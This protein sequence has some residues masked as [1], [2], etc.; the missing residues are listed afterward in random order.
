MLQKTLKPTPNNKLQKKFIKLFHSLGME[1]FNSEFSKKQFTNFQRFSL[2][3]FYTKEN[4]SLRQFCE[5]LKF[6]KW[7]HY[8]Q[9]K[10]IPKKSTLNN[11]FDFFNL[12]KI[13]KLLRNFKP[14]NKIFAIDKN[15]N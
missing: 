8:L 15:R 1:E 5:D 11:W 12:K 2:L 13:K 7:Q 4:K 14:K 9:L 3:I 10:K 6:S